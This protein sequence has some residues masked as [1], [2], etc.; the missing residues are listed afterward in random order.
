MGATNAAHSA[1][2]DA[3]SARGTEFVRSL[4]AA[5]AVGK[6]VPLEWRA[7]PADGPNPTIDGP[8]DLV[9]IHVRPGDPLKY[10]LFHPAHMFNQEI[11]GYREARQAQLS[12]FLTLRQLF[13][14]PQPTPTPTSLT[15]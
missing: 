4:E 1:W 13:Q 6:P 11:R 12:L 14:Y 3:V 8:F 10:A 9:S 5:L 2:M 7:F 15:K